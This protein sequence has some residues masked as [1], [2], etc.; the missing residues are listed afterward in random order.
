MATDT[1]AYRYIMATAIPCQEGDYGKLHSVAGQLTVD[2]AKLVALRTAKGWSIRKLVRQAD[3]DYSSYWRLEK[4]KSHNPRHE[5]IQK[6]ATALDVT[7]EDLTSTAT[8][9]AVVAI[10]APTS[11]VRAAVESETD[12]TRAFIQN[13]VQETLA[14]MGHPRVAELDGPALIK[15]AVDLLERGIVGL[16]PARREQLVPASFREDLLHVRRTI[17]AAET[18]PR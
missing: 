2:R 5:T 11:A 8:D 3:V 16:A 9:V 7:A 12:A 17:L 10:P 14:Q 13:V 1:M 15:W 6:V 4:G 18:D